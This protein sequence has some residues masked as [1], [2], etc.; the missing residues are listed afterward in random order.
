MKEIS[1]SIL[2]ILFCSSK[3]NFL[4][5]LETIYHI[6]HVYC[7]DQI[8]NLKRKLVRFVFIMRKFA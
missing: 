5:S 4:F 3:H 1:Q 8:K 6:C 2:K 7:G